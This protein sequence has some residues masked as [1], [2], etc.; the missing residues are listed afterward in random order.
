MRLSACALRP[1]LYVLRFPAHL[2]LAWQESE[3]FPRDGDATSSRNFGVGIH[4]N[5]I[6][7]TT[8]PSDPHRSI[9]RLPPFQVCNFIAGIASEAVFLNDFNFGD[10]GSGV[11]TATRCFRRWPFIS[12]GW[13]SA[14]RREIREAQNGPPSSWQAFLDRYQLTAALVKYPA[15]VV[16]RSTYAAYFR[17]SLWALVYWDDLCL[18]YLRRD[19]YPKSLSKLSNS[20]AFN[21]TVLPKISYGYRP[22]KRRTANASRL[23]LCA[24][25]ACTPKVA[26]PRPFYIL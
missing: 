19:A 1:F 24:M 23:T 13:I 15:P 20:P 21:R 3:L 16:G 26:G 14:L 6:I 18:L 9:G 17:K 2:A 5:S 12:G 4:I 25:L 22:S 10:I 11:L 8:H 7:H